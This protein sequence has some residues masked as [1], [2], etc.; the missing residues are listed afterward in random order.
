MKYILVSLFLIGCTYE[1]PL[2]EKARIF[3]KD[4]CSCSKGLRSIHFYA[5]TFDFYCS[6]NKSKGLN[7]SYGSEYH[8]EICK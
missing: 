4:V 3:A 5:Y 7:V 1:D 6:D 8:G 2:K